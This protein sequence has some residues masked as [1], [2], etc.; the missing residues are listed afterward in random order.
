MDAESR[1]RQRLK[2]LVYQC[3]RCKLQVGLTA[4]MVFHSTKLPLDLPVPRLLPRVDVAERGGTICITITGLP[5]IP[6]GRGFTMKCQSEE[7]YNISFQS[8]FKEEPSATV[9]QI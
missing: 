2:G 8:A 5:R 6:A 3:N 7:V 9:T 1:L 4:G